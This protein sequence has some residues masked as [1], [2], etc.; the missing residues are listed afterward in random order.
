M[1]HMM[2][3][4]AVATLLLAGCSGMDNRTGSATS[5]SSGTPSASTS[6]NS[7]TVVPPAGPGGSAAVREGG[8]DSRAISPDEPGL[9]QSPTR[10][11]LT[12]PKRAG[13]Q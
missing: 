11:S 5:G 1:R 7:T 4:T 12:N 10:E 9:G 6:G 3:A 2:I 13:T 8:L